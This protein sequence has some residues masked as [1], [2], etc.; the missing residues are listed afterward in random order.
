VVVVPAWNDQRA[1]DE[2]LDSA[3]V[4]FSSTW[5]PVAVVV[6]DN[7]SSPPLELAP[8]H[9]EAALPIWLER[10]ARRGPAAARNLGW[11]VGRDR[12]G[13]RWTLF[14]DCGCQLTPATFDG[15]AH[16]VARERAVAYQGTVGSVGSDWLS[17]YYDM[18]RTLTPPCDALGRPAYLITANALVSTEALAQVGGFDIAFST[19]ASE[20]VELALRLKREVGQLAFAPHAL[21]LHR[22]IERD[23]EVLASDLQDLVRRFAR[24]GRGRATLHALHPGLPIAFRPRRVALAAIERVMSLEPSMPLAALPRAELDAMAMAAWRRD[25]WEEI[26]SQRDR[27]LRRPL[28]RRVLEMGRAVSR[29]GWIGWGGPTVHGRPAVGHPE[30]GDPH[31]VV[32]GQALC[33]QS[34]LHRRLLGASVLRLRVASGW[35]ALLRRWI[36]ES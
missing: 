7:G 31:P 24:Y 36:A 32:E 15:Y 29:I 26:D 23:G 5:R 34:R 12:F 10:E 18:R 30:E 25:L 4:S 22:W 21:V 33:D 16:G 27:Q 13:S 11:R 2:T 6:V 28:V 8:R 19:A 17:R 20:D 35:L 14:V 9:L 3:L 1:L